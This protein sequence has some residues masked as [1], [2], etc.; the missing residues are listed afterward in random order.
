[1]CHGYRDHHRHRDFETM[2]RGGDRAGRADQAEYAGWS[3]PSDADRGD[4]R[5]SDAERERVVEAL[6]AHAEAGRL[7]ADELEERVAAALAAT[8]RDDLAA[9]QRDLPGRPA[10]TVS[11]ARDG[12]RGG[13]SVGFLPIALLLVAIWALTGAGYFWPMWPLAWFAFAAL[14]RSGH[15]RVTSNTRRTW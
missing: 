1:M 11:R 14:M 5:A 10:P 3:A 7:T 15:M 6:R 12:G 9:L 8:T 13:H 2:A 4:V